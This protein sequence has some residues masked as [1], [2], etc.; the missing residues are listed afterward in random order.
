MKKE[1]VKDPMANAPSYVKQ[2][3]QNV[4]AP[5]SAMP[6]PTLKLLQQL[7]PELDKDDQKYLPDASAG[8]LIVTDGTTTDIIDGEKGLQFSPLMVR[9]VWTEWIPRAKGGGFV[10]SY[11]TKAEAEAGYTAGNEM[12]ISIDYLIV[13]P[14]LAKNGVMVPTLLSFNT[15]TKMA[16]AREMQKFITQYK[17]MFGVNYLLK[18]KKQTNKAGQKFFN[19][20][21]TAQGWTDKKVYACIEALAEEKGELFLPAPDSNEF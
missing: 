19:F 1:T 18:C 4:P 12:V 3:E 14:E 21:V 16:V 8:D 15:P 20:S 2:G 7:S 17:T 13:C 11:K 9:K 5:D 10:A 6:F